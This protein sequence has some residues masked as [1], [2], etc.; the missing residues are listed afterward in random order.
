MLVVLP[1][2]SGDVKQLLELLRWIKDLGLLKNHNALIVADPQTAY[3]E[4]LACRKVSAEVFGEV[5]LVSSKESVSGWTAGAN[6]LF[7]TACAYVNNMWPQP[8]VWLETDAIPLKS[9]WLDALEAEYAAQG[10]KYLGHIYDSNNPMLPQRVMSG[11]AV[12]PGDAFAEIPWAIQSPRAFDVDYA[13]LFV[14]KGAHTALIHHLWGEPGNPPRFASKAIPGTA[15]FDLNSI[16][17]EAVVWHRCKDGSLIRQL[18]KSLGISDGLKAGGFVTVFPFY[19]K[20]AHLTLK[21]LT[22]MAQLQCCKKFD[23]LLSFENGVPQ[24][25]VQEIR[26]TAGLAFKEVFMLEYPKAPIPGW[27][28]GPNWAFQHTANYMQNAGRPW[29][30][31]ETDMWAL[32][33]DWLEVLQEEYA[34]CGKA[35]M[36]HIVK[37]FGHLQGTSIYPADLPS[38]CPR[39]MSATD[40]AFDTVSKEEMLADCHKANELFGHAWGLHGGTPHHFA[41]TPIHFATAQQVEAWVP[42]GAVTFHRC[43]DGS[44]VDR[45]REMSR[46]SASLS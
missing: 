24:P 9:G 8:W 12:Y 46:T 18:R 29:L 32:T 21:G 30:W 10:R 26:R 43:K 23:A 17:K 11:V 42:R 13:G 28:S 37:D 25:M 39:V 44:I 20:D 22:W 35:F 1:C 7:R 2:H 33:P 34:G 41:G 27:P 6:D 19:A 45:L 5:R 16:P 14:E 31:F 36:G 40:I 3:H 15:V 4:V 38:R